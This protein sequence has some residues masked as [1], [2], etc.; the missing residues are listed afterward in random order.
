MANKG[1]LFRFVCGAPVR[2]GYAERAAQREDPFAG[3]FHRS[4]MFHP[5]VIASETSL[6]L[7]LLSDLRRS[8]EF[9]RVLEECATHNEVT[10]DKDE[11]LG[12]MIAGLSCDDR[13]WLAFQLVFRKWLHDTVQVADVKSHAQQSVSL[14][15]KL[16]II[17][18]Y[19]NRTFAVYNAD[20]STALSCARL[21]VPGERQQNGNPLE[22]DDIRDTAGDNPVEMLRTFQDLHRQPPT[23]L[24]RPLSEGTIVVSCR[25]SIL[26]GD[27]FP[28]N[29]VPSSSQ[30]VDDTTASL[31]EAYERDVRT[32]RF[33]FQRFITNVVL[34]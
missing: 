13:Y 28:S 14:L 7:P 15:L 24:T 18:E 32:L 19:D 11:Y 27:S 12:P 17:F 34:E 25:A 1:V 9:W 5:S 21:A 33:L 31:V 20:G 26:S 6:P 3:F 23:A 8:Y 16:G 10:D 2:H 4:S 30:P 22:P 29:T